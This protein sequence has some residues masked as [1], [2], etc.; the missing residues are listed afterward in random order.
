VEQICLDVL[1]KWRG[2]EENGRDDLDMILRE[3]VVISDSEEEEDDGNESDVD[4]TEDSSME[5]ADAPA[6]GATND[7]EVASKVP[8]AAAASPPVAIPKG[9]KASQRNVAVGGDKPKGVSKKALKRQRRAERK[10]A[11]LAKR[12]RRGLQRYQAA[13]RQAVDRQRQNQNSAAVANPTAAPMGRSIS[14]GSYVPAEP[15][16]ASGHPLYIGATREPIQQRSQPR[17]QGNDF[18]KPTWV[19]G[20]S[21]LPGQNPPPDLHS[22]TFGFT[23][24]RLDE[25]KAV[26]LLHGQPRSSSIG[27][28]SPVKNVYQDLLVPS[29]EP[30]SPI[31]ASQLPQFIR[32]LPPRKHPREEGLEYVPAGSPHFPAYDDGVFKRRRI[33]M[34]NEVTVKGAADYRVL[35]GQ[36]SYAVSPPGPGTSTA[37]PS[38]LGP[39]R[40]ETVGYKGIPPPGS[41]PVYR[42]PMRMAME[43]RSGFAEI[44]SPPR[45][46]GNPIILGGYEEL[47]EPLT[48]NRALDVSQ[49]GRRN[50]GDHGL[51]EL[52]S[53]ASIDMHVGNGR[54]VAAA[55]GNPIIV[56]GYEE[57]SEPLAI[58]R[59]LDVSQA[60]RRNPGD[61]GLI[62]LRS[63]ASND[64]HSGNGRRMAAAQGISP[65]VRTY[66]TFPVNRLRESETSIHYY[67]DGEAQRRPK[68]AAGPIYIR[69]VEPRGGGREY[70]GSAREVPPAMVV[71]RDVY[72]AR[73]VDSYVLVELCS[74]PSCC[75]LIS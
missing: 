9:P 7:T 63:T 55:H 40:T 51:I 74:S 34:P 19:G 16:R 26:R 43:D 6:A 46:R 4:D 20:P 73:P 5:E 52:R 23:P 11:I 3:V 66:E 53:T 37:A 70:P 33:L 67:S 2:D 59:T 44:W 17:P 1:V 60:G 41:E 64:M 71:T 75:S 69:S 36:P 14:H 61:H 48:I 15:I 13:W 24:A 28:T 22:H 58:N 50:P 62:D 49:A 57:L 10:A 72:G 18:G 68:P 21:G 25:R 38:Y 47:S 42:Q 45:S 39:A 54:R 56:G 35:P 27:P 29:I 32:T 65:P 30:P 12:S 31:S 8:V